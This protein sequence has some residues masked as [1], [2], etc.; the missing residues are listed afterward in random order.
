MDTVVRRAFDKNEKK[1][2]RKNYK[3]TNPEAF[4]RQLYGKDWDSFT[5]AEKQ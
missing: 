5:A 1:V 2:W 3:N 4:I